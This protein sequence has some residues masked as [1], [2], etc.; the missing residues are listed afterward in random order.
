VQAAPDLDLVF[1]F[2]AH[3]RVAIEEAGHTVQRVARN[4]AARY[5]HTLDVGMPGGLNIDLTGG[6]MHD[7]FAAAVHFDAKAV[8]GRTTDDLNTAGGF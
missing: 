5:Q 8:G 6:V 7:Q 1:G 2:D 3:G 4:L